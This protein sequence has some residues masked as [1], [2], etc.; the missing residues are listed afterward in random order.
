MSSDVQLLSADPQKG[1]WGS[2]SAESGSSPEAC[3]GAGGD[4]DMLEDGEVEEQ[5]G[6]R[7]GESAGGSCSLA[8][9]QASDLVQDLEGEQCGNLA[10]GLLEI[11]QKAGGQSGIRG[12]IQ[13]LSL[14]GG[15][16]GSD[17]SLADRKAIMGLI[18]S[19]T[20]LKSLLEPISDVSGVAG[21]PQWSEQTAH[22][23]QLM[24]PAGVYPNGGMARK[25]RKTKTGPSSLSESAPFL[26]GGRSSYLYG[27]P[28]SKKK[29]K[30]KRKLNSGSPFA[31]AGPSP[32][33]RRA[34]F[35][36]D[37]EPP[38]Y[39]STPRDKPGGGAISAGEAGV[40]SNPEGAIRH[41]N[42][43]LNTSLSDAAGAFNGDKNLQS[44][45]AAASVIPQ[46]ETLLKF[47]SNDA[48]LE[49]GAASGPY[50]NLAGYLQN[51]LGDYTENKKSAPPPPVQHQQ[52]VVSAV[53]PSLRSATIAHGIAP[54][55]KREPTPAA[56]QPPSP[57]DLD[58]DSSMVVDKLSAIF[59]FPPRNA[60]FF[61]SP[62]ALDSVRSFPGRQAPSHGSDTSQEAKLL[63]YQI[64]Q[65]TAAP[66]AADQNTRT[67]SSSKDTQRALGLFNIPGE[68]ETP[69]SLAALYPLKNTGLHGQPAKPSWRNGTSEPHKDS[70]SSRIGIHMNK[71]LLSERKRHAKAN[72]PKPEAPDQKKKKQICKF[73][74]S[75]S[76]L[77][78]LKCSYSHDLKDQPCIF[79][80]FKRHKGGCIAKDQC[81]YSHEAITG[82]QMAALFEEQKKWEQRESYKDQFKERRSAAYADDPLKL[83]PQH[84]KLKVGSSSLN[85]KNGSRYSILA[86]TPKQP[87]SKSRTAHLAPHRNREMVPPVPELPESVLGLP[88]TPR[89]REMRLP[90][91]PAPGSSQ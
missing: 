43:S 78:G 80:H 20:G 40:N 50:D 37:A 57:A 66:A 32:N 5:A 88:R 70:P 29:T 61:L 68:S 34:H 82:E 25:N 58:P 38:E 2:L 18:G 21:E 44:D 7:D 87:R 51:T 16:A 74:K 27:S 77:L 67:Y 65:S 86:T 64:E 17:D 85:A 56:L 19:V 14:D 63:P 10:G 22:S 31:G 8:C 42:L 45:Q 52:I 83:S 30:G 35:G 11:L 36:P 84:K 39:T 49:P 4:G 60:H 13:D 75:G 81:P 53:E 3:A 15:E 48:K 89:S 69:S 9:A 1:G 47:V 59:G 12:I 28:N 24:S 76:C 72:I 41:Q 90:A 62:E 33:K 71:K 46:L 91:T 79:Y 55:P 54:A 23:R 6:P 26:D 73:A